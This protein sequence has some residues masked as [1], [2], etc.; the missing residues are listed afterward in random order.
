MSATTSPSPA[1]SGGCPNNVWNHVNGC[2]CVPD[3][4]L[5]QA[6]VAAFPTTML[7]EDDWDGEFSDK[8]LSDLGGDAGRTAFHRLAH[9]PQ[10]LDADDIAQ[11]VRIALLKAKESGRLPEEWSS[12]R[13]YAHG[14]ARKIAA[15][16]RWA[17]ELRPE[18]RRAISILRRWADRS[19]Q[20]MGRSLTS[21]E[22][23]DGYD[24]VMAE[25]HDPRRK[26]TAAFKRYAANNGV[27]AARQTSLDGMAES[28]GGYDRIDEVAT[29][30]PQVDDHAGSSTWVEKTNAM[31]DV[32]GKTAAAAR[33]R[34]MWNV[35]A[36]HSDLPYA[37]PAL[38]SDK[39][40]FRHRRELKTDADVMA[41][42]DAY[43]QG[44]R[45]PR[46]DALFAPYEPNG[47]DESVRSKVASAFLS[48]PLARANAH[49]LWDGALMFSA[50]R[51]ADESRRAW[52]A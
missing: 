2:T 49:D 23:L 21:K 19:E 18:D 50:N 48:N 20:E 6:S 51:Y 37:R 40:A 14:I 3:P 4:A 8:A 35:V 38:L 12:V 9:K 11:E 27:L 41:A 47:P 15:D 30:L 42:A 24:R 17:G 31:L 32:P 10:D 28:Y 46:V 33:R 5:Q 36:E 39:A 22:W 26:P 45:S 44:E 29:A 52:D 43:E 25:W 1:N 34:M 16:Q 7:D 13:E